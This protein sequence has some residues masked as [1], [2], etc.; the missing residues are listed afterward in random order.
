MKEISDSTYWQFDSR[1]RPSIQELEVPEK[2]LF[3]DVPNGCSRDTTAEE[4]LS[5]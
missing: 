2:D 1:R 5:F 4:R 3:E